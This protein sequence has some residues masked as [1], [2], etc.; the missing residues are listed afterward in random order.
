MA[1]SQEERSG[2]TIK[3]LDTSSQKLIEH[4]VVLATESLGN[5]LA[6]IQ[7]ANAES[8]LIRGFYCFQNSP[9]EKNTTNQKRIMCTPIFRL[10]MIPTAANRDV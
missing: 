6:S 9:I 8:F 5:G 3:R 2:W 10:H 4:L 1:L 7:R